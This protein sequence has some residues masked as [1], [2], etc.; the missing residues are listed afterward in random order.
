MMRPGLS[1]ISGMGGATFYSTGK[2]GKEGFIKTSTETPR[3]VPS[4]GTSCPT[5]LV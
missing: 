2:G 5:L 1:G 3:R 4:G